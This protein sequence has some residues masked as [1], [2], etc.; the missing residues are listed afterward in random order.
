M[1]VQLSISLRYVLGGSVREV[2]VDFVEVERITGRVIADSIMKCLNAWSSKYAR[3]DASNMAGAR[4]GCSAIVQQVAPKAVY[5]HYTAHRLNHAVLSTCKTMA[6]KN[7][8][9]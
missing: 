5:H 3:P 2:F 9:L 4:S 8:E 6:F 7:C 1:N